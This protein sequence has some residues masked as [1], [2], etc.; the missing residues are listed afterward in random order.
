MNNLGRTQGIVIIPDKQIRSHGK[1]GKYG[2]G[3]ITET[4]DFRQLGTAYRI[5]FTHFS[6]MGQDA[7]ILHGNNSLKYK[8]AYGQIL[9]CL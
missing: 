4:G 5:V 7:F 8:R 9:S 6:E 2:Y 1:I 3:I